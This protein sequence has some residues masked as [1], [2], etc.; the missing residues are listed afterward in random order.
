M[1]PDLQDLLR[2]QDPHNA[3]G[4]AFD[5]ILNGLSKISVAAWPMAI[6]RFCGDGT[7][8]E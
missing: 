2:L 5:D 8:D 4:G 6:R 3:T 1:S 7:E